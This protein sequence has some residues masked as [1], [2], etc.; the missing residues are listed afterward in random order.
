M[1]VFCVP[2]GLWT[3]LKKAKDELDG[4][5]CLRGA[6]LTVRKTWL[7]KKELNPSGGKMGRQAVA[8]VQGFL[9]ELLW[10]WVFNGLSGLLSPLPL[11]SMGWGEGNELV[12][13]IALSFRVTSMR[14]AYQELQLDRKKEEKRL[15]NL[16]GKKREQA[17]RLGMGLVSRRYLSV[18]SIGQTVALEALCSGKVS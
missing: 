3:G 15:Q 11:H 7:S 13:T 4:V 6:M 5:F 18:D 12:P 9:A 16:E 1:E 14:L 10:K 17:E 8:S 2:A